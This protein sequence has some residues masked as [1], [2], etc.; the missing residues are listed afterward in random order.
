MI[1]ALPSPEELREWLEGFVDG[2]KGRGM[3][4]SGHCPLC[5]GKDDFSFNL[6]KG[7]AQCFRC[8]KSWGIKTL[9]EACGQ[10]LPPSWKNGGGGKPP[11][12]AAERESLAVAAATKEAEARRQAEEKARELWSASAPADPGHPYLARKGVAPFDLRQDGN[13]LVVPL[14]D[15]SGELHG[16]QLIA[17]DG[18]KR[19]PRCTAKT[20]HFW[21]LGGVEA[22]RKAETVVI[23]EGVATAGSVAELFPSTGPFCVVAAMD[24]AEQDSAVRAIVQHNAILHRVQA[25]GKLGGLFVVQGQRRGQA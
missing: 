19:Y 22:L 8:G 5:E 25:P 11:L 6:E 4:L 15:A 17:P 2:V 14:L 20:G 13:A 12:P 21:P 24:A 18:A 10:D 3:Q 7:A 1:R 23:A 9:A 16:V